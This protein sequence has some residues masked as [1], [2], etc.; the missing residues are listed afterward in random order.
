MSAG[1]LLNQFDEGLS[2]LLGQWNGYSTAIATAFVLILTY[3]IMNRVEPDIHPMLLARQASG[4]AVRNEG[5]SPVYRGNSAPHSMPLNGGLNVKDAGA[6][7]WAP[8]RDGDLRDVW[9]R[10][11]SGPPEEDGPKGKGRIM[12]VLG[13]ESVIEHNL[14]M[15]VSSL[16][17]RSHRTNET[18]YRR[19]HPANQPNRTAYHLSRREESRHLSSQLCR[20]HRYSVRLQLL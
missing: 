16:V 12:T 19:H 6:S 4:S 11:V 1:G 7:K 14:S 3:A 13:S 5:E 20:I 15:A 10:T 9:R 18:H 8:G 2:S 17:V